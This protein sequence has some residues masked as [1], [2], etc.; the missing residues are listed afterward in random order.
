MAAFPT[1]VISGFAGR[2]PHDIVLMSVRADKSI[3]RKLK[4]L[5][6]KDA[7]KVITR[8]AR[9]AMRPVMQAAKGYAPKDSGNLRKAIKLRALKKNR[10][11][12]IGVRVAISDQWFVG[13]MFYGAFQEFGWHV[14]KRDKSLRWGRQWRGIGTAKDTR[15][16]H[17]GEHFM[18]QAYVT[19][20]Q[21]AMSR[22]MAEVPKELERLANGG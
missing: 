7:K 12:N 22:F 8:A 4:K 9:T 19:Q 1:G 2:T 6:R 16:F 15:E 3:M 5:E 11:G 13:K 20:G 10:R 18:E 14:G 21:G 17:E